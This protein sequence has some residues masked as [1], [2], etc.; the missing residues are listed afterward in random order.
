MLGVLRLIQEPLSLSTVHPQG[1]FNKPDLF[2]VLILVFLSQAPETHFLSDLPNGHHHA[3]V[4]FPDQLN[5]L[6]AFVLLRMR[7][8]RIFF[9][10]K[11][12]MSL[13]TRKS[14]RHN[15]TPNSREVTKVL[16]F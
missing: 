2:P 3:P 1:S 16:E 15:E 11:I 14:Y 5:R 9:E 13:P 10:L 4:C 8:H 6:P 7:V 12:L